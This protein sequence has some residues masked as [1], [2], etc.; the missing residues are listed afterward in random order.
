[1]SRNIIK[2]LIG[3]LLGLITDVLGFSYNIIGN[4]PKSWF[5]IFSG[6]LASEF[7]EVF[8]QSDVPVVS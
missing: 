5:M 8:S 4:F 2:Y 1:M 6:K 7:Q 3:A